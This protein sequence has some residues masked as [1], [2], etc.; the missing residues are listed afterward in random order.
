MYCTANFSLGGPYIRRGSAD[1]RQAPRS[2]RPAGLE[3]PLFP[4][5][6][7]SDATPV[8][9]PRHPLPGRGNSPGTH[10]RGCHPAKT[11]PVRARPFNPAEADIPTHIWEWRNGC[12]QHETP[13]A[14][15]IYYLYESMDIWCRSRWG[16]KENDP[17][18]HDK[19][20]NPVE[21]CPCAGPYGGARGLRL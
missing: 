1:P 6:A 13:I 19:I 14:T 8:I 4:S 2:L 15:P 17:Y 9:A 12:Q 20:H 18:T 7:C 16:G 3:A 5:R 21:R 10:Y 11:S